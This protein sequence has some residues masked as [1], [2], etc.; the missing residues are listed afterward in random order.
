MQVFTSGC[1]KDGWMVYVVQ[2]GKKFACVMGDHLVKECTHDNYPWTTSANKA[3]KEFCRQVNENGK[4]G[5]K[6]I[7]AHVSHL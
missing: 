1:R 5:T 7:V 4:I 3:I 2:K 6:K